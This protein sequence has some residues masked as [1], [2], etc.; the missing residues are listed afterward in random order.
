MV[1]LFVKQT[2]EIRAI[3]RKGRKGIYTNSMLLLLTLV[4]IK[5][6]SCVLQLSGLF[7]KTLWAAV[8]TDN[9]NIFLFQKA[10]INNVLH[11]KH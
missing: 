9:R 3:V 11:C 1:Y 4:I 6:K 10:A 8:T 2:K 7:L 5:E